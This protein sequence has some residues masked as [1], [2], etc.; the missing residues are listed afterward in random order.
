MELPVRPARSAGSRMRTVSFS[1]PPGHCQ[2]SAA[3]ANDV[4]CRDR[5]SDRQHL[6][7]YSELPV[8]MAPASQTNRATSIGPIWGISRKPA[9]RCDPGL[10]ECNYES[11]DSCSNGSSNDNNDSSK[12]IQKLESA[13]KSIDHLI[14][15]ASKVSPR[16]RENSCKIQYDCITVLPPVLPAPTPPPPP[17]LPRTRSFKH[18]RARTVFPGASSSPSSLL[19]TCQPGRA[20][21]APPISPLTGRRCLYQDR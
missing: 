14:C 16:G 4:M 19:P 13:V 15:P 18:Y 9:Q 8:K 21:S 11:L 5:E 20:A 12:A 1:P 10:Y 6:R 7:A 2:P 3:T 17:P